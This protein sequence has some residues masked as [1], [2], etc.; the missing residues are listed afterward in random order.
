MTRRAE[1]SYG[2]SLYHGSAPAISD[3]NASSRMTVVTNC[4]EDRDSRRGTPEDVDRGH[5]VQNKLHSEGKY[6]MFVIYLFFKTNL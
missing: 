2:R 1:G 3:H 4:G 6:D 5:S